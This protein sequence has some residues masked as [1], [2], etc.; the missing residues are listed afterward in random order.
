MDYRME[1]VVLPKRVVSIIYRRYILTWLHYTY[2]IYV[3][4]LY[5]HKEPRAHTVSAPRS[6]PTDLTS[7]LESCSHVYLSSWTFSECVWGSYRWFLTNKTFSQLFLQAKHIS[8]LKKSDAPIF[9]SHWTR[10]GLLVFYF[11]KQFLFFPLLLWAS[12]HMQYFLFLAKLFPATLWGFDPLGP[13]L[14]PHTQ[15]HLLSEDICVWN[16]FWLDSVVIAGRILKLP[17]LKRKIWFLRT[18][19]W[20][21]TLGSL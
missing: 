1:A 11:T 9:A 8:V 5:W 13:N 3:H 21:V 14:A 17:L 10:T 15:T 6:N 19:A 20:G 12:R 16:N 18:Q 4:C 7:K 2:M